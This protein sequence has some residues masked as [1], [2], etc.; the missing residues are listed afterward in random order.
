[1]YTCDLYNDYFQ[2]TKTLNQEHHVV[3][4]LNFFKC[5]N[6]KLPLSHHNVFVIFT[7]S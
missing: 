3:K 5:Q 1:M 2:K 6:Y 7:V 4:K